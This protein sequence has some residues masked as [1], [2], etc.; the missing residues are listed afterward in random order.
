MNTDIDLFFD[1]KT[2]ENISLLADI[3]CG[4]STTP[5]I[6]YDK[7]EIFDKPFFTASPATNDPLPPDHRSS[8]FTL[9]F[10]FRKGSVDP[11]LWHFLFLFLV[12][13]LVVDCVHY[14]LPLDG[15][16]AR[17]FN[18]EAWFLWGYPPAGDN[19]ECSHGWANNFKDALKNFTVQIYG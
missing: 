7:F 10:P 18:K 6:H 19:Y 5:I 3:R 2:S 12:D 13:G 8:E 11:G 14:H 4:D 17:F 9:N 16:R 1:L 15:D